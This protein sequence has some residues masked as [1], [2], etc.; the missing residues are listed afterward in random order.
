[1]LYLLNGEI[2]V[3]GKLYDHFR[4]IHKEKKIYLPETA[5]IFMLKMVNYTSNPIL[6]DELR[7]NNTYRLRVYSK[8]KNSFLIFSYIFLIAFYVF[9]FTPVK[10]MVPSRFGGIALLIP[11]GILV[12]KQTFQKKGIIVAE[13]A[14]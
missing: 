6:I 4:V 9:N 2:W 5:K 11:F 1:M 12:Y 8:I 7:E 14:Y 13:K 10:D 3:D